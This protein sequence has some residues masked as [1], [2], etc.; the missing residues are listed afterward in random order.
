MTVARRDLLGTITRPRYFLTA[1]LVSVAFLLLT[2]GLAQSALSAATA[3][4][5]EPGEEPEGPPSLWQRGPEG[6]Y[7]TLAFG[8][9]PVLLPLLA[10]VIVYD[11]LSRDRFSGFFEMILSRPVSRWSHG[12]GKY[13][14]LFG[15]TLIPVAILIVGGAALIQF[16]LAAPVPDGLLW[17]VLGTAFLLTL[18]Y[19]GLGLLLSTVLSQG[20]TGSVL[21]LFWIAF[22]AASATGLVVTA[23]FLQMVPIGEQIYRA[24]FADLVSFTGLYHGLTSLFVPTS[25]EFVFVPGLTDWVGRVAY[26]MVLDSAL[27]WII[28]V[29]L[30]FL[31]LYYRSRV[32]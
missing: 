17:G 6:V 10:I 7:T 9:V 28:A 26:F 11:S 23:Q 19:V 30:I 1:A 25:L 18:L 24:D 15:A 3:E 14:G 4:P 8:A 29:F 12:L 27:P 16:T 20:A 21:I 32:G 5:P 31:V 2:W 13:A 22:N